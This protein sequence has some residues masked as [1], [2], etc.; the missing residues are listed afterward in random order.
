MTF[1]YY[2]QGSVFVYRYM[3]NIDIFTCN[4]TCIAGEEYMPH[5]YKYI[6]TR[7]GTRYGYEQQSKK[8]SNWRHLRFLWKHAQYDALDFASVF[9]PKQFCLF[10]CSY[11]NTCGYMR[12]TRGSPT[13]F[14]YRISFIKPPPSIKPLLLIRPSPLSEK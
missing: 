8:D 5:I 3:D 4:A 9:I 13:Y 7:H 12:T 1:K 11:K 14:E 10:P 2:L 6:L